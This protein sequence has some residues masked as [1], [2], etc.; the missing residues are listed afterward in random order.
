[1][2]EKKSGTVSVVD[3]ID[4]YFK[5]VAESEGYESAD[6]PAFIERQKKLLG[7]KVKEA[8]NE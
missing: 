8:L 7:E 1:V 2:I 5:A 3:L 6:I 4:E